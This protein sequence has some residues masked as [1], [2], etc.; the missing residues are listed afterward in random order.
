M[1]D[2]NTGYPWSQGDP[3]LA[4]D[5]NAAIAG[6]SSAIA[7]GG[8]FLPIAGGAMTG[9]LSLSGN[10]TSALHAVPLQQLTGFLPLTG[11]IMTG[12]VALAGVPTTPTAT[13]GTT[14]T[15]IA[16]TAFVT[17]AVG[18]ATAGGPF[19]PLI[20]GTVSGPTTFQNT[21]TL[22]KVPAAASLLANLGT[23][24][25][26]ST[27]VQ[28]YLANLSVNPAGTLPGSSAYGAFSLTIPN[29]TV[30]SSS[31][32]N[33]YS[34]MLV[35]W[36]GGFNLAGGH[37]AL[38][39]LAKVAGAVTNIG[40]NG[41]IVGINSQL[42]GVQ[43]ITAGNANM[44]AFSPQTNI[45]AGATGYALIEAIEAGVGSVT[46]LTGGRFG[47]TM[48][49][50]GT[51]QGNP[52]QGDAG[53]TVAGTKNNTQFG[54]GYGIGR[55]ASPWGVLSTGT[56]FGPLIQTNANGYIP[57]Q[58][59]LGVNFGSVNFGTSGFAYVSPGF[60][61]DTNGN[62]RSGDAL[63]STSGTTVSLDAVGYTGATA[64]MSNPG[65]SYVAGDQIYDTVCNGILS[66]DT[67]SAGNIATFHWIRAPYYFGATPPATLR[68]V[69][70][71]GN[72]LAVAN[73]TWTQATTLSLQ[74]SG[75]A[76]VFGG[77]V[78]LPSGT[79]GPFLPL[80]GGI[81]SMAESGATGNGTTDDQPVIQAWLNTLTAGAEV[82]LPP[83]KWYYIHAAPLVIPFN[84]TIR[85]AY[86][87]KDN[88]TV[89]GS[90]LFNGGGFYIDPTLPVG[91]V[92]GNASALKQ[93]KV[94]R[95]GLTANASN[96]QSQTDYATWASE[97]VYLQTNA[98]MTNGATTIPLASTTGIA[99]GMQVLGPG[100]SPTG[101]GGA[102][103]F[104]T[105]T[106]ITPGVSVTTSVGCIGAQ[107]SGIWLRFGASLGII[108]P[109]STTG[110]VLE[111]VAV[112]GFRTGI[113]TFPAQFQITR[114]T[115]DC[116]TNLE[117]TGGSDYAVTRDCEWSPMYGSPASTGYVR[118]GDM[119]FVHDCA[120]PG[121]LNCFGIG[122]QNG[123]HF[124]NSTCACTNCSN[125][126]PTAAGP[127]TTNWI[128]KSGSAFQAFNC[129]AQGGSTGFL[130]DGATQFYLSGCTSY[131]AQATPAN[132]VAH[133]VVQNS[134]AANVSGT[135]KNPMTYG[136][137]PGKTP[138]QWGTGTI[139][140]CELLNPTIIDLTGTPTVPFI[141]GTMPLKLG[142]NLSQ[143]TVY[144]GNR[145]NGGTT[146]ILW[147][148]TGIVFD[149][150]GTIATHTIVLPAYPSDMQT[151]DVIFNIAVTALTISTTDGAAVGT[152]ASPVA[153]K[154]FRLLYSVAQNKWFI[155]G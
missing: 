79:T 35:N 97:G 19:L 108:F 119:V 125:E 58:A 30:D 81:H 73:V 132:N 72:Q 44:I 71:N 26:A 152:Y 88:Q 140:S 148:W 34:G 154:H 153:G 143:G 62:V 91:I 24:N 99:L 57:Q 124:E 49:S 66:V 129:H 65:A 104:V 8:P 84:V 53:I 146:T 63:L 23:M 29:C 68:L 113:T 149:S 21:L 87:A 127:G 139:S 150:V 103:T 38:N 145:P 69:G 22:S 61:V 54:V 118:A 100:F 155:G 95:A 56:I 47:M 141:A 55:A 10:A 2:G 37:T 90:T 96:T 116:I 4:A 86:G 130:V 142:Q 94:F 64:T 83:G 120:G 82:L 75:G 31:N 74:P 50:L 67:V 52:N 11:G 135:I 89:R 80:T 6:A 42:V 106:A 105:V 48:F 60:Q 109:R 15:Q 112:I 151:L 12:A 28:P 131:G 123:W 107:A 13:A 20:G 39:V 126:T 128:I 7:A 92:I 9:A 17:A 3:L 41:F 117:C 36:Q 78:T 122:W 133:F 137:Y 5:L 144:M 138:F 16:S 27:G 102:Y 1:N 110:I 14:T 115:G 121:F 59:A 25:Y 32:L 98:G 33:G 111:D 134:T 85:G 70:G 18:T 147:F 136:G 45:L 114:C 40:T 76:T 51:Q 101:G 43:P 77:P 46:P 93:A